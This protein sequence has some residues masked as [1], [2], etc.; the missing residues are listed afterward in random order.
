[1]EGKLSH[2]PKEEKNAIVELVH[3]FTVL[4]PDVPDKTI[5]ACHDVDVGDAQPIKQHD[6][7]VNPT[8]LAALRKEVQC[9]L[10]SGVVKPSQSQWSSPCVLVPKVDGNYQFCTNFRRVNTVTKSDFLSTATYR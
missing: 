4:F 6:Y 10:H 9:M 1:M 8:K 3:K 5:C 2:L 7:K